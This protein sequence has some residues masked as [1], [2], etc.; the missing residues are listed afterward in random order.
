MAPTV[1][2]KYGWGG[3]K[4]IIFT[5]FSVSKELCAKMVLEGKREA[6][7][8]AQRRVLGATGALVSPEY[9]VRGGDDG[10]GPAIQILWAVLN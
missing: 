6:V 5:E 8:K 2:G 10:W 3:E 9:R 4:E 1:A 7:A